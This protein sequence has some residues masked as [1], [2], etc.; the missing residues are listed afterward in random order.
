VCRAQADRGELLIERTRDALFLG[1]PALGGPYS[2]VWR[3]RT[4]EAR[5]GSQCTLTGSFEKG[6]SFG[7]LEIFLELAQSFHGHGKSV[8]FPE[9]LLVRDVFEFLFQSLRNFSEASV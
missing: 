2:T 9:P 6:I 4:L 1:N 7:L 5:L 3:G 8:E